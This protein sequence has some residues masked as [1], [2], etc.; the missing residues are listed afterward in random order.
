MSRRAIRRR[1]RGALNGIVT[2]KTSAH[3]ISVQWFVEVSEERRMTRIDDIA[4]LL[5][6]LHI[7]YERRDQT[8]VAIWRTE[9][10]D[11]LVLNFIFS[12]NEVWLT[13]VGW[14]KFPKL[15]GKDAC[16]LYKR[17]LAE[18]WSF[19]GLKFTLDPDGD[20]A[21]AVETA[22]TEITAEELQRYIRQVLKGADELHDWVPAAA[23]KS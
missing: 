6:D 14:R 23:W 19:N 18:S 2:T 4:G 12:S 13:I 15:S 9:K 10:W 1:F 22:D 3:R 5:D 17:L 8:I 21:I 16:N 20:I 7:K 11:D